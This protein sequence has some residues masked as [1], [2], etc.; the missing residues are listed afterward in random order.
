MDPELLTYV[1]LSDALE[2]IAYV[3]LAYHPATGQ[4]LL[5]DVVADTDVASVEGRFKELS[6]H[7]Y[8]PRVVPLHTWFTYS[9]PPRTLLERLQAVQQAAMDH[10]ALLGAVVAELQGGADVDPT[11][12]TDVLELVRQ[13]KD[14]FGSRMASPDEDVADATPATDTLL[15]AAE[16]TPTENRGTTGE[17]PAEE[18]GATDVPPA[19][20]EDTET[21]EPSISKR[22]GRKGRSNKA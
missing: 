8:V 21:D 2:G 19:A 5:L 7:Q 10:Q 6:W 14:S 9:T 16:E 3:A 13:L 15:P 17:A 4:A 12:P 18:H 11:W 22:K 20:A 1:R